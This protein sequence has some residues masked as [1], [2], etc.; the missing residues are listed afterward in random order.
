MKK[1]KNFLEGIAED[2]MSIGE[3]ALLFVIAMVAGIILIWL[4][5]QLYTYN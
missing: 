1:I 3:A 5:G 2:D 4:V